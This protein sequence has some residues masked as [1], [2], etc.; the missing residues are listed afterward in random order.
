M[1]RNFA[2]EIYKRKASSKRIIDEVK[3]ERNI[4]GQIV[5]LAMSNSINLDNILSFPLTTVP[6]SLASYDGTM[7]Q[8]S[9]TN[10]LLSLLRAKSGIEET[11]KIDHH[12]EVIDGFQLLTGLKDTR[13]K[14]GLFASFLLKQICETTAHK[15]HIIFDKLNSPTLRNLNLN[16]REELLDRLPLSSIKINGENQERVSSLAKCLQHNEFREELVKFLIKQWK[17][18]DNIKVLDDKR[19]FVSFDKSCYIFSKECEL[20]KIL[21]SFHNNHTEVESKMIFHLNKIVANDILLRTSK[22]EKMLVYILYNMQYWLQEKTIWMEIGDANKNT[23]RKIKVNKIYDS[24]NQTMIKALPAWYSFTG[25]DYEPFFFGKGRK[26]CFKHF[27]KN[28]EYQIAFANFG[29][30]E[31]GERDIEL[32]EKYTC[33]LYGMECTKVN[34][35]RVKI[36]HR[37]YT[38]KNGIDL[39]KK[40]K[41][42][43][44]FCV[45]YKITKLNCRY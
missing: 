40:G 17:N 32:I 36:F 8:N 35:A 11:C 27:E 19:V 14:Y 12:V 33:E 28:N 9:K 7:I 29:V 4:L 30:H 20:G 6:H 13:A 44:I 26:T 24:F 16:A 3:H 43:R 25:C 23:L 21:M 10:E 5:C 37:A 39:I 15:I 42:M 1:I 31:P 38:T 18:S 34:E 41:T 22:P 45:E 2:S